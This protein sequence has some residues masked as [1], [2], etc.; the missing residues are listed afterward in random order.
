MKQVLP[1][2]VINS[3]ASCVAGI[4]DGLYDNETLAAY[5]LYFLNALDNTSTFPCNRRYR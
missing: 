5:L 2:L 4:K 1:Q 3:L